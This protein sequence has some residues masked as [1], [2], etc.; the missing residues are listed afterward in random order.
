[1]AGFSP[2]DA[3]LEGFRLT[4]ERPKALLAWTL[5]ALLISVAGA[6]I[7][8]NMPADG[9]A[10]LQSLE[11]DG[12]IDPGALMQALLV[13]SPLLV[14]GL[15]VQCMM[16]AA[17]YRILLRPVGDRFSYLRFGGDELRLMGLT[18]IYL[19][20]AVFLI[21]IVQLGVALLGLLASIAGEAATTFVLAVAELFSLGLLIFVGIRMSLAPVITFDR[22]KLAVFE[23]W[24][25]TRGQFWRLG[26]AYLLAVCCLVVLAV[27]TLVVFFCLSLAAMMATGGEVADLVAI[28]RAREVTASSYASPFMI[29]YV[30]I[31]SLFTAMYYAVLAAP[32]AFAY[33]ALKD[34]STSP[35][36]TAA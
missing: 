10:A 9:R 7:T 2:S 21:A 11:A 19:V 26:G 35:P 12:A 25:M 30:L 24:A 32:G 17:V 36:A 1:M 34:P 18:L 29:A 6:V 4:R 8:I 14:F 28:L 3:A 20:L 16:A 27:V 33:R 15:S 22:G 13:L 23:S 5:F 31:G